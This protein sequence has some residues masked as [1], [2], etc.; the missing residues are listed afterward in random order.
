MWTQEV[1]LSQVGVMFFKIGGKWIYS[2]SV[3]K[4]KGIS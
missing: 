3:G 1:E 4:G 2:W